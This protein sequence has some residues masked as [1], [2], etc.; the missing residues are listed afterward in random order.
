M[1]EGKTGVAWRPSARAGERFT[2]LI[3]RA[4][5]KYYIAGVRLL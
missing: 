4:K 2:L 1:R 5:V 3:L